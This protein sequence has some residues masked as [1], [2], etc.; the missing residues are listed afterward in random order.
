M[1]TLV[2]YYTRTGITEKVA[3]AINDELGGNLEEIVETKD[4]SGIPA[5]MLSAL[6]ALFKKQAKIEQVNHKP[7][8]FDLVIIGTPVWAHNIATPVRAY[9]EQYKKGFKA[10]AFFVTCDSSGASKV[11]RDM[12]RLTEEKSRS[13]LEIKKT[14]LTTGMFQEKVRQF[15]KELLST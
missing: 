6:E 12:D 8:E 14:D 4:R 10:T 13:L 11:L 15:A 2:V 1:K 5:Y 3:K 7:E 9:L